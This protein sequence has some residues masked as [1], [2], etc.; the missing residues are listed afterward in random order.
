M[1]KSFIANS[2]IPMKSKDVPSVGHNP[3]VIKNPK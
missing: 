2:L 3:S 1:G